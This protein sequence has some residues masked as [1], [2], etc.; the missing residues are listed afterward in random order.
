[1]THC[2]H[3][4]AKTEFIDNRC[5]YCGIEA[6]K[7]RSN[8]TQDEKKARLHAHSIRLVAFAHFFAAGIILLQMSELPSPAV[9]AV[10]VIVNCAL[11]YGLLRFSLMAYRAAVVYYFMFGMVNV[12][13]IQRGPEHL[14]GLL[15]CL[16]A[17]Y[18]VGN[19][20]AKAIFERRPP[21]TR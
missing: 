5:P 6:N 14:S 13:S 9:V 10:L 2:K 4:K 18:L 1:M 20:N 12:V 19:R 17:L 3:C 15:I 7:S 11:G 16:F 21:E 8:L